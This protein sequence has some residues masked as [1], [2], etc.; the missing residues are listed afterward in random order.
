MKRKLKAELV[1]LASRI[2][3]SEGPT[4]VPQLYEEA[5]QLYEKLAVLNFIEEKLQD[6]QVDVNKSD[7]AS[8]FETMA[9]AVLNENKSVPESNPHEED[10]IIPGIDTIKHMVSEMPGGEELEEVLARFIQGNDFIKSDK[11]V[12]TPTPADISGTPSSKSLN[13][14]LTAKEISV[15]LNDR[16]AFV[17]HLFGDSTEDFNR[18][19]SQLN[20]MES[21]ERSVAFVEKMVKPEYNNWK[22]KEEYEARFMALIDRRFS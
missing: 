19:L 8:K 22:G 2:I 3:S 6:V 17:K 14:T 20:T 18:I 9:S 15:G 4:E 13:D 10:I 21:Q 11:D 1:G 12:V 5:R 7:V 16:L